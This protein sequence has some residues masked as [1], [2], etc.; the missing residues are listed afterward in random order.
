MSNQASESIAPNCTRADFY[1]RNVWKTS[2][3]SLDVILTSFSTITGRIKP[4]SQ[5]HPIAP[6]CTRP[7]FYRRNVWKLSFLK[8]DIVF[9]LF[10]MVLCGLSGDKEDCYMQ[11]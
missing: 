11:F 10:S 9:S 6:N 8:S 1:H 4:R 7:H 3:W 2:I 5:L